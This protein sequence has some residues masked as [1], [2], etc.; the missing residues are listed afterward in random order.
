VAAATDPRW[1]DR[2]RLEAWAGE[3]SVN[4]IRMTAVVV[5]YA[6]HLLNVFVL[7][8]DD[9][10]VRGRYHLAVTA[11]VFAWGMLALLAH[12]CVTRRWV[13]P[14]LKYATTAADIILL[15]G[16]LTLTGDAP[17]SSLVVLF[18]LV[19][20]AA[21]LRA[22]LPLV[23]FATLGSIIGY[24]FLVGVYAYWLVGY[25]RYYANTNLRIPRTQQVIFVL[26]LAGAGMTAG[27]VVRKM[28]RIA[29]GYVVNVKE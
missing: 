28:R 19:V 14:W 23:Y 27:Q 10:T 29:T 26:A 6:Y 12:V 11:A 18:F 8:R 22:S 24:L 1:A 17:K 4:R 7:S 5:F 9:P 15:T 21:P 25:E 3:A 20:A 16:M 2:A 13:P